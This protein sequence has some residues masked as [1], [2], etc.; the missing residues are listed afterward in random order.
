M[1]VPDT[2]ASYLNSVGR[3]Q[4]STTNSVSLLKK[5]IDL[6]TELRI[7]VQVRKMR[8]GKIDLHCI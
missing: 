3:I 5:V 4:I 8:L 1:K 2:H 6:S 7:L